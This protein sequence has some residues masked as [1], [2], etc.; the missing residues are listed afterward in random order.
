MK[1]EAKEKLKTIEFSENIQFW[2][3]VN[4]TKLAVVTNS[5]VYHVSIADKSNEVKVFDRAGGL[6]DSQFTQIIG[7]N[8]EPNEKWAALYGMNTPDGGKTINGHIQLY[9]IE[10]GKQQLLEGYA[11]TFGKAYIHNDSFQSTL[12]CFVEKKINENI[13]KVHINEISTAPEGYTKH[14]K[15]TEIK[16]DVAPTDFPIS[17]ILSEKYGLLYIITK[18]AYIYIYELISC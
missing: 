8:L 17:L 14:K 3:W 13:A 10:G 7:Y 6:V 2:K 4:A 12:F 11:C 15:N 5:A 9:F 16:Y 18:S 1:P